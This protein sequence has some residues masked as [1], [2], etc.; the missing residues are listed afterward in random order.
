MSFVAVVLAAG[1]GTRMKSA[2]PK[3]LHPVAGRPMV[4]WPVA[5]ARSA[6][7]AD[8]IVVVGYGREAIESALRERFGEGAR[9]AVQA[10]Q[11]GTGDAVRSALPALPAGDARVVVL[12]GDCPLVPPEALAALGRVA[13]GVPLAMLTMTVPDPTGYGRVLRDGNGRVVAVRE[14]RDASPK[15]REIR[16]V[17]PG[18]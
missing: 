18:M 17:N 4:A 9:T 16:E 10:E 2:L 15:E 11:R 12:Y 5:T 6:G 7:A 1:Q 13:K 14:H 8:V 3:V